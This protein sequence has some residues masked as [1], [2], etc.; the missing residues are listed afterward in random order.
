MLRRRTSA[1]ALIALAGCVSDEAHRYYATDRFPERPE[2]D[3]EVLYAAPSE[4]YEVIADFQA[5]R[6]DEAYMRKQAAKIGA[7]AVIVGTYGGYRS[8]GDDWASQDKHNDSYT[9]ITG[10]AIRYKR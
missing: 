2:S 10:T 1:V 9:R 8:K 7:D 4:P 3:V 5:R 6:A